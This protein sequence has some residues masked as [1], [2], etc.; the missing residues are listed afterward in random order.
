MLSL[1][2]KAALAPVLVG[3]ALLTRGRVPRL[4]EAAGAREGVVG[5]GLPLRLLVAGDSSAAG[6][7]VSEQQHALAQPLARTLARRSGRRVSWQL[8]A[9]TGLTTAQLR[10]HLR[11]FEPRVWDLVVVVTG[12]NDVVEQVPSHHA[13]AAR[14]ALANQ[15]RNRHGVQ[16]VAFAPLPPVHR[17]PALPQ[18][19]RWVAGTDA[20][21]HNVA[22]REWATTRDDVSCVDLALSLEPGAMADDGFHPGV[23]AYR[24]CAETLAAHLA[25]ILAPPAS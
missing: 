2:V 9:Q 22:L 11:A 20:R 14:D 16:H 17:F 24:H 23:V 21:R 6:V 19:L 5:S 4:P 18:P 15:L 3:Q 1:A 8:L 13:V 12:V 10:D 25:A 7:G